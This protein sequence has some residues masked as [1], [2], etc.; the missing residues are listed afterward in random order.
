[1]APSLYISSLVVAFAVRSGAVKFG[2]ISEVSRRNGPVD[3]IRPPPEASDS[4]KASVAINKYL[5]ASTS[6]DT[7]ATDALRANTAA[8][9]TYQAHL[10]KLIV[11]HNETANALDEAAKLQEVASNTAQTEQTAAQTKYAAKEAAL[12]QGRIGAD[13]KSEAEALTLS[14]HVP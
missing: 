11:A 9:A 7:V 1:M 3:I 5:K 4:M 13:F 14:M 8:P 2:M 6:R 10:K 12:G